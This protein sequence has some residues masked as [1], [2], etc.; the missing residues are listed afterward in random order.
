MVAMEKMD[1]RAARGEEGRPARWPSQGTG[2]GMVVVLSRVL[3]EKLDGCGT[4]VEAGSEV[5]WWLGH[6]GRG[7]DKLGAIVSFR[8]E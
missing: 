2:R 7:E 8:F 3:V 1:C 4:F 6:W 5:L